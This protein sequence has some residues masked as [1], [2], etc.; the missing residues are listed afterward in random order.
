M[1]YRSRF[2]GMTA[3]LAFAGIATSGTA[4]A[5][6]VMGATQFAHNYFTEVSVTF[7]VPLAPYAQSNAVTNIWPGIED[8]QGQW[9]LQ[10]VLSYG[11]EA[12]SWLM[13]NMVVG[14]S[15]GNPGNTSCVTGNATY[16]DSPQVVHYNDEIE[17]SI[18]LDSNNPGPNC[19]TNT[20]TNCNYDVSWSDLTTGATSTLTDWLQPTPLIWAQGLILETNLY[21]GLGLPAPTTCYAYPQRS[22]V[23]GTVNLTE[24]S[25]S[26]L[27]AP[28]TV[29]LT[30]DSPG[31]TNGFT[32]PDIGHCGFSTSVQF[33]E[34]EIAL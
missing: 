25:G 23:L 26:N 17:A 8:A 30:K 29:N 19:N 20:G 32:W 11:F 10:P 16:C 15:N 9:V 24:K 6:W 34:V 4:H 21:S 27:F 14:P 22:Y 5:N 2:V 1:L 18:W 13:D 7:K 31:L 33:D 3:V 28:D 12:E